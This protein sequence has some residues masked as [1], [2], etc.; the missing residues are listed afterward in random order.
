MK[1][2]LITGA[3]SGIGSEFAR[4]CAQKGHPLVLVARDKL[5]LSNLA[6]E[7]K[8]K[9]NIPSRILAKDL[10]RPEAPAEIYEELA[11]DSVKIDILINNAGVGVGGFFKDTDLEAELAMIRLNITALTHLTKLFLRDMVRRGSGKILNVASTAAFQPGPTMSIY[12]ASKAYVLSFS[13][14]IAE[15]LRGT[16][17]TV[18]CLCPGPTTSNFQ[19]RAGIEGI[20]LLKRTKMDAA[21]VAKIGY[22]GLMK[23]RRLIIPGPSNKFF[24]FMVRFLPREWI[25]RMVLWLQTNSRKS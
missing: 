20:R 10:S 7:L 25:T 14:A 18:S 3:S 17:I 23:K 21:T 6:E 13:E 2:A 15:E 9:Y 4:V 12:Y 16:N 8:A 1:T 19:S 5:A 11:R 22:E 24:S